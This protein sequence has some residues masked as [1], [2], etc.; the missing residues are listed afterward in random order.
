MHNVSKNGKQ[1][2]TSQE[3]EGGGRANGDSRRFGA[4]LARSCFF[5]PLK[6]SCGD[7]RRP[8]GTAAP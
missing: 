2:R 1:R 3:N 8:G 6:E 7:L 5:D 4:N